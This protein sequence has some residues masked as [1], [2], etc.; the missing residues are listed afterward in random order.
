MIAP[1]LRYT[2][3][4]R[5]AEFQANPGTPRADAH[6]DI[7]HDLGY[8]AW[9]EVPDELK[10]EALKIFKEGIEKERKLQ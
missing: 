7:A 8:E 5:G 10:E 3:R 1:K 2:I 4:Y 9:S 6:F